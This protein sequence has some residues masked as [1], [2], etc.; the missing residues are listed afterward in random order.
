MNI[1]F[2]IEFFLFLPL[3]LSSAWRPTDHSP[4]WT[5]GKEGFTI[6]PARKRTCP[7]YSGNSSREIE[8]EG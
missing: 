8:K 5:S 6:L 7:V 2:L 4:G 3:E 1:L